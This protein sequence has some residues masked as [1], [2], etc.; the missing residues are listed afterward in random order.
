MA[1]K[2]SFYLRKKK[3]KKKKNEKSES[4]APAWRRQ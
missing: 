2:R 4:D 1:S 3:K